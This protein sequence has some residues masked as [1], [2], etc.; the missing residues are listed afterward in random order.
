M[1][2]ATETARPSYRMTIFVMVALALTL[3]LVANAL[4][5]Y[6]YFRDELYYIA[7]SKHLAPGYVDQPPLSIFILA[8][9]RRIVG[10]SVFAIRLVPA[11]VAGVSLALIGLLARRMGGGRPA[12]VLASLAFL[13]APQMLIFHTYFSMNSLDIMFWLLAVHALLGAAEC[14]GLKAW[15]WL[16]LVVGLGLLNK[17]SVLWLGAGVAS[18]VLLTGLRPQLK[19]P[20]PYAAAAVAI[21][22][23]S[24]F[25]IWNALHGWP[26]IEFMRNATEG[27]Y[28]S[29]TRGRFLVDQFLAMN[30]VTYFVSLPGLLLC[31]ARKD[32]RRRQLVGVTFLTVFGILLANPHVKSE[33]I[34]AAYP[35]LFA[36]G[37]VSLERLGPPWRTLAV[38]GIPAL[39]V[40]S[41][42]ILAPLAIPILPVDSYLRYSQTLGVAPSTPEN[43]ELGDL[44]QFF[45]DMNGWED[46]AQNV[47][48]AYVTIPEAERATTVAFVTNYGEAGA[49][50]L[51]ARRYPLPRVICNHNAYWFWGVGP[52]PVTTF[53]RLGGSRHDYFESYGDVTPA[54]LHTCEHCMPYENNLNIFI[55]RN[56]HVPIDRAWAEYKHFE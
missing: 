24:P 2:E 43:E 25:V 13:A 46:L 56:R 16:G 48:N 44:P 32:D 31:F 10:D 6:G 12:I 47:S 39:L 27:K 36:C 40:V 26:H 42:A 38:W 49:L 7:C 3:H 55:V 52:M 15:L 18:A 28:S 19:T 8:V 37:G 4:V 22:L 41:G 29:L 11:I 1:T 21:A 9:A 30:P 5:G 20:G 34:A 45:A 33:Y 14:G 54:G 17:T 53:I 51:Y 23:F 35:M 50:E